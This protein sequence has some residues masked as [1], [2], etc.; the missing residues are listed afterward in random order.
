MILDATAQMGADLGQ[1]R[2]LDLAKAAIGAAAAGWTLEAPSRSG[3]SA[4]NPQKKCED[5]S[6]LLSPQPAEDCSRGRW[7]RRWRASPKAS[8]APAMGAV[9]AALKSAGLSDRR[10]ACRG[11]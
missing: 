4:A 1:K 7:T 8:R 5:T 6:E 10:P 9:Q 3:P 11:S 2:K